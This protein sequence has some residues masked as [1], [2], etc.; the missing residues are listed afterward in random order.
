MIT[1]RQTGPDDVWPIRSVMT[2]ALA[3]VPMG[4]FVADD[5]DFIARHIGGGEGTGL[6][7]LSKQTVIAYV[8]VRFPG[9]AADNLGLDL[10]L[11]ADELGSV[12]HM[13]SV[14]VDPE[15]QG[16]G[17]QIRLVTAAEELVR[18]FGMVWSLCTVSP[19]NTYSLANFIRLGYERKINVVKYGG[20]ER[21]VLAKRL[22]S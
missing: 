22:R 3:S 15:W 9:R 7:A 14:A 18:T 13:E 20:F 11:P 10:G 4:D 5:P 16:H 6:V 1:I 21:V 2:A 12:A 19:T 8:L 17:L